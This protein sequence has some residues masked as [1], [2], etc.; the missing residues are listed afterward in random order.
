MKA[1]AKVVKEQKGLDTCIQTELGKGSFKEVFCLASM[2]SAG[3]I[4]VM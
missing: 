2:S 1:K 3:H 4:S